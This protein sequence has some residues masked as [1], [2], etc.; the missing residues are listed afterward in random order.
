MN[1]HTTP[2]RTRLAL[3]AT[4]GVVAIALVGGGVAVAASTSTPQPAITTFTPKKA[5]QITN[6]D[7]LRQQ[8]KNYYGDP[9]GSGTFDPHGNYAD[10]AT[11]VAQRGAS[12]LRHNAWNGPRR[13]P[14]TQAAH[15]LHATAH[16][17]A[18]AI[19][20][21]VD[22]TTLNTWNYEIASNFA[23]DPVSNGE[24]VTNERFPAVP[25]MVAT[26]TWAARHGYAIFYLTGRPTSQAGAT[27]GNLTKP[28]VGYP[29]PATLPNGQSGL[30][31]KPAVADYPA[32]LTA[33]CAA[34]P[35]GKCT[36]IHYKSATRKYIESA[37]FDIVANFGDQYSDLKGG[38]ADR[39]FK[40]PNP[41]YFLP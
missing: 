37:G 3:A 31:T 36:T 18:R 27:L 34:D 33:A 26:V 41:T 1:S 38:F 12:Y 14:R 16:G 40:L 20:L 28:D 19:V 17:A 35:G 39:T 30:F 23:Y 11:R 5:D 21:D 2:R 25:G 8:I 15:R 13:G 24:F 6:I 7:V 9:L 32:Y 10:E 22:D 29:A 4:A